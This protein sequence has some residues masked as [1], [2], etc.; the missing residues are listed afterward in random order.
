MAREARVSLGNGQT[1][2]FDGDT[3]IIKGKQGASIDL[4]AQAYDSLL[5]FN[6]A[7][8]FDAPRQQIN[9]DTLVFW[10]TDIKASE[11]DPELVLREGGFG[12]AEFAAFDN[13]DIDALNAFITANNPD[14]LL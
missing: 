2:S 14:F 1:A 5:D 6:A 4:D 7:R 13:G 8:D 11:A 9:D 3:L 12:N 10:N